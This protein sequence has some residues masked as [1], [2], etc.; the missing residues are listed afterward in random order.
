MNTSSAEAFPAAPAGSALPPRL[1]I[2]E[3]AFIGR[4]LVRPECVL[5]TA[6]GDLYTADFRGGVAHIRPDRSQALYTGPGPDGL[7]LKP[8]GI[9][10]QSD[11]SFLLTQLGDDDGGVFHLQRNGQVLPIN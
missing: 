3:L 6:M 4:E 1:S 2:D 8:N 5:A 11:G 7:A 9:A 10:L